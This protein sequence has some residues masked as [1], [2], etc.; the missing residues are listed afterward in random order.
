MVPFFLW[1]PLTFLPVSLAAHLSWS[2]MSF[3]IG[4]CMLF[5]RAAYDRVGGYAA[6]R[7]LVIDDIALSRLIKQSN[8][9][10]RIADGTLR[11][12]CR[13]YR[14]WR[15]VVAGFSKNIFPAFGYNVTVF[16]LA[17]LGM[18]IA[19]LEPVAIL[20]LP[21]FS[22][23]VPTRSILLAGLAVVLAGLGWLFYYWRFRYPLILAVFY[24]VTMILFTLVAFRSFLLTLFGQT[25]WKDRKLARKRIRLI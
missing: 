16:T 11:V 1:A 12:Q 3:A 14:N 18:I 6:V 22:Q 19:F 4:Q 13:M 10:W 23:P 17:W 21:G 15:E 9:H 7:D 2:W 20:L 25:T 8:L 24:P 5:R